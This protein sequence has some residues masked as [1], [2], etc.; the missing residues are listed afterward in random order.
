MKHGIELVHE[1]RV[2]V[3]QAESEVDCVDWVVSLH[4]VKS[5]LVA[6]EEEEVASW[7]H[8]QQIQQLKR[9]EGYFELKKKSSLLGWKKR[10]VLMQG[11][12]LHALLC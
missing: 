10:W 2:I 5:Q 1:K 3:L 11:M 12:L 6:E 9:K 7:G 4:Q 8:Y